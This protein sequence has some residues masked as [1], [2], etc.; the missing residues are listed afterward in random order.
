MSTDA[1]SGVTS[2]MAGMAGMAG[3][4]RRPNLR[5]QVSDSLRSLVVAG[6]LEPGQVYSAPTLAAQFGVSATPVREAM[7]DLAR[8]GLVEV[9]RNKGFRITR[10]SDAELDA[11]AEL[12]GLIEIPVMVAVTDACTGEIAAAVERL[13]PLAEQIVDAAAGQDL[14]DYI[15]ADTEFHLAFLAL[16]GNSYVVDVVR[17]LRARARLFGLTALAG[18]GTLRRN[19][20]EHIEI[21]DAALAQDVD[22]MR[23]LMTD[24][25]GHLRTLWAGQAQ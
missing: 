20:I 6:E 10:I 24:H 14:A 21:V 19:A 2:P 13:R 1:I 15:R 17:D 12:R 7:L 3:I 4:A 25:I 9:V 8:E 22:E 23:R 5:D 18:D 16:H 11:M